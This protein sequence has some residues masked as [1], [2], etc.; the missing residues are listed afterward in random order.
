MTPQNPLQNFYRKPKFSISLPSR[1]LWYPDVNVK[2]K[3]GVVE[4]FAMTAADET[5]FKTNEVLLSKS[6]TKSLIQSCVP[7]IRDPL[8][9]PI[10]D[11]DVLLLS[12][13]RAS[14]GDII[15]VSAPV[16]NTTQTTSFDFSIEKLVAEYPNCV[17]SWNSTMEIVDAQGNTLLFDI[18][19]INMTSLFDY[20]NQLM[21]YQ[22]QTQELSNSN[23]DTSEKLQTLDTQLTN[24]SS[25][26]V[27]MISENIA[28]IHNKDFE[29]TKP[30][31]I[32]SF[33]NN[34]DLDY[35]KKIQDFIELQKSQIKFPSQTV[36]STPE[37]IAE[38]APESWQ[39]DIEFNITNFFN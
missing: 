11:L 20:T 21:Q 3:N 27:N 8:T 24:L 5:K 19:P 10:V 1:G 31:D 14:Y 7:D 9:M 23:K 16:P 26:T 34:I 13:R 12:I 36:H 39:V 37:Q 4:V 29:I 6:A 32:R 17:D 35:F 38:G 25:L 15:T 22:Q 2:N 18:Q 30:R 33:L 28:K